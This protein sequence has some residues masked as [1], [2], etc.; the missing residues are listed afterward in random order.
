MK[1][2]ISCHVARD[3]K[4]FLNERGRVVKKCIRCREK[5]KEYTKKHAEKIKKYQKQYQ[6]RNAQAIK[7]QKRE[8]YAK[9]AEYFKELQ[10]A[11]NKNNAEV[12]KSSCRRYYR[13]NFEKIQEQKKHYTKVNS[14]KIRSDNAQWRRR[15]AL[16]AAYYSRLPETDQPREGRNGELLVVCH[17][18]GRS[19]NPSNT[20]TS[21]RVKA[22]S[23]QTH[24]NFYFYCGDVCRGLCPEYRAG[25]NLPPLVDVRSAKWIR[26]VKERDNY[27]CQ[28]CGSTDNLCAHH[29]KPVATHPKLAGC[30]T[31][32]ITLCAECHAEVHQREG[33][34]LSELRK[35]SYKRRL[36]AH[37][38]EES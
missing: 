17:Y 34:S 14:E 20:A 32:G 35:E 6:E 13:D 12:A 29:I 33:M 23:G 7:E 31:N 15:G 8:Y 1:F 4:D 19:F 38:A 9:H 18:C 25:C 37:Y 10:R 28:H 11:W 24:G 5:A 2:C 27:T 36:V 21:C 22:L 26:K 3:E 16:F 30:V